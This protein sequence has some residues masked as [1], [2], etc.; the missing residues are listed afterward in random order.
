MASNRAQIADG[1]EGGAVVVGAAL[2][3]V[4]APFPGTGQRNAAIAR[5]TTACAGPVVC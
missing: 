4:V 3:V 2:V 1:S 5:S